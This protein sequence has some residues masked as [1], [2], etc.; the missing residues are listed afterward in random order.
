VCPLFFSAEVFR[1]FVCDFG[2]S[3][4]ASGRMKKSKTGGVVL[5]RGVEKTRAAIKKK[6]KRVA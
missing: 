6:V 3:Y 5:E 2:F 4:F 1:I